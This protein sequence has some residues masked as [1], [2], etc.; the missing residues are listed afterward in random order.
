MSDKVATQKIIK[1][2]LYTGMSRHER[3]N[4][5]GRESA[6]SVG[7]EGVKE[8]VPDGDPATLE[9]GRTRVNKSEGAQ[10]A[11]SGLCAASG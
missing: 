9:S 8:V 11:E 7:R 2:R 3:A 5:V 10:E 4:S 6:Y 1:I